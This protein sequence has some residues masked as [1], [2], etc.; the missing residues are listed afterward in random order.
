MNIKSSPK[1]ALGRDLQCAKAGTRP[2]DPL[3]REPI[4]NL[5]LSWSLLVSLFLFNLCLSAGTT[6]FSFFQL[7]YEGEVSATERMRPAH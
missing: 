7:S 6:R 4:I 3:L 5:L 1:N 2:E